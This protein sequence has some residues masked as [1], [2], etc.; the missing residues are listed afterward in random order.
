MKKNIVLVL[1]VFSFCLLVAQD[2]PQVT[3]AEKRL[4]SFKERKELEKKSLL[5]NM[6]FKNIG[7]TIF[8]GRAVDVD[9]NPEDP[10]QFYVAFAS[11]GLWRTRNNG[12]SFEPLFQNQAAMT[13]GDIRVDWKNGERI[14]VGT[15]ESNAFLF[16]GLGVYRSDDKG[17]TWKHLGLGETHSISRI[18]VHPENPDIVWAS[19]TGHLYTNNSERGVFKTID[20]GKTWNKTLFISDS[21]ALTDMIIDPKNP[22]VLYAAGWERYRKA[23]KRH[24]SGKTSGIY[25]STDGG[26]NWI[27][28]STP[29]SGFPQG[30]GIGRIGLTVYPKNPN[31]LYAM[32]DNQTPQIE[33]DKNEE[34]NSISLKQL[35]SMTKNEFLNLDKKSVENFVN[36]N[37]FPK[38]YS[39]VNLISMVRNDKI[40]P[41]K[42][43]DYVKDP[44]YAKLEKGKITGAEIYRSDD[45]GKT[46]N[47]T[48]KE[49]I[50]NLIFTY[51]YVFDIIRVD[52]NNP[53]KFYIAGVPILKSEDAGKSFENINGANVHVDH[54]ALWV[55]PNKNGHLINCNDGGINMSYDDGKT[56]FKFNTFPVG[57]V[58]SLSYDMATPYNIYA[59]FQDNGVWKGP[60]TYSLSR[61]WQSTG[62]YPYKNVMGGDGFQTQVDFRD[63]NTIYTGYQYGSYFRI[64]V[65]EED[66]KYI[67][68]KHE[69]GEKPL[70]FNWE[71]PIHL[72]RHNQ[73]ILYYGANKLY[74]SLDKGDSFE[75][76]SPDLSNG[77]IPGDVKYGTLTTIDESSFKFGLIYIG[78]DDG[79]VQ[80]T[81]DGGVEWENISNGLPSR[82]QISSVVASKHKKERVYLSMTGFKWDNTESQIYVSENFG[83][84]WEKIG[85]N[86][87]LESTN[88]ILEDPKNENLLYVGTENGLYISLD[89]GESFIPMTT[90]QLPAV[91]VYDIEVHPRENHLLVGTHGRSIYLTDVSPLQAMS[92]ELME[93]DIHIFKVDDVEFSSRWGQIRSLW[94]KAYEGNLEIP[95]YIKD[96][97]NI[98]VL[99]QNKDGLILAKFEKKCQ[100]GLNY[101]NYN[102]EIQNEFLNKF[103]ESKKNIKLKEADNKKYYLPKGEYVIVIKIDNQKTEMNFKIK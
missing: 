98:D 33:A 61:R 62:D 46:W 56:W 73:D 55:N 27:K 65:N 59:G 12:S 99:I 40:N 5:K 81:K 54:H 17:K 70:K 34:E 35:W 84:N 80:V 44:A 75:A 74:R 68:P 3:S 100:K 69:L 7:P 92:T 15:G 86:L 43:A 94:S 9:V 41:A 66:Y 71:S 39:A 32:L 101:I 21:T 10:T 18:I 88:V 37:R 2:F 36:K 13:I 90:N 51:G 30:D 60:H 11:G 45:G 58:Y 96:S 49:P 50:N 89:R 52:P 25:K 79:V 67:Q 16:S 14:W 78:T 22:D 31:I 76:I 26:E 72:S 24:K 83:K 20:G 87:P 102:F 47:K 63:N 82:Y 28:L 19:G 103:I 91:S 57:Q 4:E 6:K 53:D 95:F 64:K 97:N 23:W 1:V 29:E 38:K 93:K 48:H 8:S 77:G 42:I 85:L